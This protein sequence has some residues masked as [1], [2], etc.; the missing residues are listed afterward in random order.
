MDQLLDQVLEDLHSC[1]SFAFVFLYVKY[2]S[3]VNNIID[4]TIRG[5]GMYSQRHL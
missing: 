5:N 1:V 2:G 4:V 3:F